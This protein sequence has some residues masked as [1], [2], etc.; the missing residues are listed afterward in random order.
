MESEHGGESSNFPMMVPSSW[1]VYRDPENPIN[2]HVFPEADLI[3]H[4]ISRKCFCQVR[5]IA[6]W[7]PMYCGGVRWMFSHNALDGRE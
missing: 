4:N 3:T 2:L 7:D 5:W 1:G 6:V